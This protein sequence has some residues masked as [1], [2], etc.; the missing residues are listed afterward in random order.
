MD[1]TLVDSEPYWVESEIELVTSFGGV[2]TLDDAHS[3][4]GNDLRV[5]ARALR[6][7]GGVPLAVE[8]IVVKLVA[9][10]A[11][12]IRNHIPWRSG[13]LELLTGLREHDVACALVTMSYLPLVEAVVDVLP[14]GTFDAVVT[15]DSV[16]HGKPHPEPYATA[17]E[18]L[19]RRPGEC[20][21][22]EDS[23]TGVRSAEAAG[24]PTI[25]VLNLVEIPPAPGRIVLSSLAGV[26]PHDLTRWAWAG[27]RPADVAEM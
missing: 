4:V 8:E 6:E 24:I 2:W 11:A 13:A 10:V 9:E 21:A 12:K 19:G 25:G 5:S 1:G 23:L 15:G 7:R 20:V 14:G 27:R 17:V 16:T 26:G 18:L 3:L 22:L